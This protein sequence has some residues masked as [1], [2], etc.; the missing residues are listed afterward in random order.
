MTENC[1]VLAPGEIIANGSMCSV[2]KTEK[3]V[4]DMVSPL[5]LKVEER[6]KSRK[7]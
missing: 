1:I 7:Q 2:E 5:G 3:P 4:I 6:F